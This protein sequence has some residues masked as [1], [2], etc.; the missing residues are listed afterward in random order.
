V[1]YSY[2]IR[3]S[4]SNYQ[5]LYGSD[6]SLIY[7]STTSATAWN[8]LLGR[9]GIASAGS[10][11][12]VLAG[13]YTITA[14]WTVYKNNVQIYFNSG[15]VM[16]MA[17]HTPSAMMEIHANGV[18]INGGEFDGNAANQDPSPTTF[19]IGDPW[20]SYWTH[21]NGIYI[22]GSNCLVEYAAVHDC[23]YC[24]IITMYST[25]YSNNVVMNC[26][27]YNIGA[28]GIMAAQGGGSNNAFI[29]NLVYHCYDVGIDSYC[30][31]TKI[32]GNI[33]HD[34]DSD[35]PYYGAVNSAWGIAIESGGGSS[36]NYLLIAG[37]TVSSCSTAWGN[38]GAGVALV[39]G[40]PTRVLVSGNTISNAASGQW[41]G[42]RCTGISNC[43]IE[44]NDITNFQ[45]GI[46]INSGSN[47]NVYGN[48]YHSCSTG[49]YDG[50]SGTVTTQP[51]IVA[52][53]VTSSPQGMGFFTA[54]GVAGYAGSNSIGPYTF[55]ATVG[56]SVTLAANY[57]PDYS[58]VSWS[59][60]G[61]Q[62]HTITVPSSDR[63]YTAIYS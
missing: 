34:C 7:Q 62:T 30:T 25:S 50:G 47:N 55:Y 57:V 16:T 2:I 22:F 27:V 59:D 54:N 21:Q 33:V 6:S 37:N 12:N 45:R 15:A 28:N 61:A 32:T 44:F 17:A 23:R 14:P 8:Y 4:G 60:G 48:T 58:F 24:G 38:G 35:C 43:I 36:G 10:T 3:V 31:D 46:G 26:T 9:N 19:L 53:T 11:V 56:S 40:S 49:F 42:I 63:T 13:A 20:G 52:V 41:E 39:G 51:S 29:N 5:V 18:T 1:Q